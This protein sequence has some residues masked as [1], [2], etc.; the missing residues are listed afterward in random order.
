LLL[1]PRARTASGCGERVQEAA[2]VE[3]AVRARKLAVAVVAISQEV[4]IIGRARQRR[5]LVRIVRRSVVQVPA[6][7]CS[8]QLAQLR[9]QGGIAL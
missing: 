2:L 6:G 3:R 8:G 1:R 5:E 7:G 4:H 9:V